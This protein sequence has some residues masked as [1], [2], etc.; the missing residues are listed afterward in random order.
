MREGFRSGQRACR[1]DN[2]ERVDLVC[3]QTRDFKTT[4]KAN[5]PGI[6]PST[7]MRIAS[8]REHCVDFN[9]NPQ[10]TFVPGAVE[11]VLARDAF[12]DGDDF[13]SG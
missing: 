7:L 1:N 4:I 2:F 6:S 8:I 13:N 10:S 11:L 9:G 3:A 5:E 12:C